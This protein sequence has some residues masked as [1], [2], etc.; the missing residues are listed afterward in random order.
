LAINDRVGRPRA[1]KWENQEAFRGQVVSGIR[2]DTEEID[3]YDKKVLIVG[4][5]AFAV[6]NA[7]TALEGGA[8][9]VTVLCRRHGTVCP[10]IID[11]L[12][13]T[14]PYDDAFQHD[15]K[16]NMRN[17][18][19]WKKLYDLS[20]AA[21]P[22]CWMGRLKH[23]GHTISVS[24]IW[25]V[26]HYLQKIRTIRG[27]INSM[28]E[29]GVL[30]DDQRHIET[31][32]VVNTIGFERNAGLARS[33]SGI[34]EIHTNNYLA[35]DFMYLADAY[36]DNEAFNSLFGSSVLEMVKFYVQVFIR[37]FDRVEF[38]EMI[39]TD[40]LERI[41]IE[42][43]SWSHYIDGAM[44]LIRKYPDIRKMAKKQVETRTRNFVES[45]DLETYLAENKRE[46]IDTHSKLAGK[47]MSEKDCLPY[48][49]EKLIK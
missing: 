46:W 26:G 7:R 20:G 29:N 15:R 45:H 16:S 9:Q 21:Q 41:P 2:N 11:Y 18:M 48:I 47:P 4:M 8:R 31:D 39:K 22:E 27:E 33:L 1:A 19:Y 35:K 28:T 13:F 17:M 3:W 42:D 38:D 36:I 23:D 10:K 24:D 40:G 37:F 30:L 44:A 14:T 5:G 49:F 32:I 34:G 25:F 6:E 43:R 12:N